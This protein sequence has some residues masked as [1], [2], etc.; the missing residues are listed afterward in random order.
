MS[1]MINIKDYIFR[2][3]SKTLYLGIKCMRIKGVK[4]ESMKN[5]IQ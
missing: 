4:M 5:N 2:I 3:F 1:L